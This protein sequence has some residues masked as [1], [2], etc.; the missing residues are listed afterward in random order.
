MFSSESRGLKP[1]GKIRREAAVDVRQTPLYRRLSEL[2]VWSAL[3]RIVR[4][5]PSGRSGEFVTGDA[6]ALID[7]V[8]ATGR[9]CVDSRVGR[10][11][12]PGAHALREWSNRESLHLSFCQD[13]LTAHLDRFSPLSGTRSKVEQRCSYSAARIAIHISGRLGASVARGLQGG[14]RELDMECARLREQAGS[15]SSE[16]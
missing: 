13:R 16:F 9:F 5:G 14:W 11:L 2:G 12:H 4:I 7:E 8:M 3:D 6:K 1:G 10:I 15:D